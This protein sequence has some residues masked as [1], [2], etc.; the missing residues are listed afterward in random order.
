MLSIIPDPLESESTRGSFNSTVIPFE[1]DSICHPL[2]LSGAC[3]FE[4]LDSA[5]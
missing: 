4:D 5:F 1:L 2:A 3:V